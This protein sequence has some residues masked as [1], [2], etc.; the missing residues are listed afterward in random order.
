MDLGRAQFAQRI[1]VQ[2]RA[3][4]LVLL[5]AVARKALRVLQH[6]RIPRGLGQDGG[7]GDGG[8]DVVSADQR[9]DGQVR[10]RR[11]LVA[12]DEHARRLHRQGLDRTAHGIERGMQ[13]VEAVDVLDA[14]GGDGKT[15]RLV[16]DLGGQ[17]LALARRELLGVAQADDGAIGRKDDGSGKDRAGQRP[18]TGFVDAGD[19]RGTA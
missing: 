15:Q 16:A 17:A 5:E 9:L 2:S 1:Q 4:A 14:G 13:D 10:D 19:Q 11:P 7:R 18:A 8:F 12:V 3:I 6:Q